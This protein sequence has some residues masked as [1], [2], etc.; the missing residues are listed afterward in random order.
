MAKLTMQWQVGGD[1]PDADA[2]FFLYREG[3][4]VHCDHRHMSRDELERRVGAIM[5]SSGEVPRYYLA[6]LIAFDDPRAPRSGQVSVSPGL[7]IIE[8][9]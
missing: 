6:A 5:S 9:A 1:S 8:D 7:A 4:N 2:H 3:E